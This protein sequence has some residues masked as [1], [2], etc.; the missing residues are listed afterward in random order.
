MHRRS[1][2]FT[3]LEILAALV[4]VAILA[5]IAI[6]SYS[7]YMIRGQ[8]A[9]AKVA[10][11]QAAQFMER[12]YTSNGC[13][14]YAAQANCQSQS[15][16]GL[17][18]PTSLQSAPNNGGAATYAIALDP[19]VLASQ[20]YSLTATPAFTDTDCGVLKLDNTGAKTATGTIGASNPN[21][22]WGR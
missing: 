5:A 10:L 19:A 9:A 4:V 16:T 2:G 17:T 7:S 20:S 1:S 6:P 22:C 21:A 13:Y 12:N 8:R 3:M 11:E 14:N 15:G 18:L